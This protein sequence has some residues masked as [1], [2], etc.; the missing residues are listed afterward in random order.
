MNHVQ[1]FCCLLALVAEY[2][3][4]GV[5]HLEDPLVHLEDLGGAGVPDC[6]FLD[7]SQFDVLVKFDIGVGRE[8]GQRNRGP[9][10]VHLP[11]ALLHLEFDADGLVLG[12]LYDR[13]AHLFTLV[14]FRVERHRQDWPDLF[15]LRLHL[16]E[17]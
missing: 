17:N 7:V 11:N 12:Q 14:D 4:L 1:H 8:G 13:D 3:L 5:D 6:V 16:L 9:L 10:G 2:A 15:L